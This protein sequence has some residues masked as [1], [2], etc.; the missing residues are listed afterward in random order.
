MPSGIRI[1]RI[2]DRIRQIV[3]V[4]L[5]SEVD[6]PRLAGVFITDVNV[7]RELE[8]ANIY[9]S[10]LEGHERAKEIRQALEHARGFLRFRLSQEIEL[11]LMPK[12][13]FFYDPTPEKAD[14]I[15]TMLAKLRGDIVEDENGDGEQQDE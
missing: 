14:R 7:D 15:D 3:S 9:F 12:L 8:Y 11:R 6:D 1:K 2:S 4:A 13:R 10:S 5:Q